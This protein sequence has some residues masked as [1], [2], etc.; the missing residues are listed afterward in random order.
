MPCVSSRLR[1]AKSLLAGL[2]LAS[3][4]VQAFSAP[5]PPGQ[6]KAVGTF[7]DIGLV[8]T[9]LVGPGP[10]PG[11]QRV[12]ASLAYYAGTADLLSIDP[13]TGKTTVLQNP[14]PGQGAIWAM[15][16]GPD[17]NIYIG[18]SPGAHLLKLDT[19]RETLV[20]LGVPARGETY[21]WAMALGADNRIYA[22]TYPNCKL[23]RYDPAN[24]ALADLGRLDPT[25][26][27]AHSLAAT[28]DGFLYAGIGSTVAKVVAY[29]ISSGTMQ[30][31][32]P[33]QAQLI[34]FG[35]AFVGLNG[36]VYATSPQFDY[37]LSG[38]QAT[39]IPP[40]LVHA[41]AVR[42]ALSDARVASLA[43]EK[44]ALILHIQHPGANDDVSLALDYGGQPNQLFRI[45]MGP[46]GLLY[47]SGA[48]PSDLARIQ[49]DGT[50]DVIGSLGSG[51]AYSM[52]PFGSNLLFATYADIS[53][54]ISYTPGQPF[55]TAPHSKNPQLVTIPGYDGCGRPLAMVA[56][57]DGLVYVGAQ[58]GYGKLT[59]PLIV[60]NPHNGTAT[61]F[62]LIANQGV[63][64]LAA[65][66]HL[67]IGGTTI[68]G[69]LGST[70]VARDAELFI[71]DPVS[72]Q[73]T[74]TAVPVA[75]AQTITDLVAAPNGL[76]YGFAGT[77][78]FEFDPS[79]GTVLRTM[80]EPLPGLIPN[81]V[82]VDKAGRIWGLSTKGVFII[83]TGEL[84]VT[85]ISTA[86]G[87]ITGGFALSG[88]T[89]YFVSGP[90]IQSYGL[91]GTLS[92]S[93]TVS[94]SSTGPSL[95]TPVTLTAV[96]AAPANVIPTGQITFSSNGTA[97]GTSTLDQGHAS[98]TIRTLPLGLNHVSASYAGDWYFAPASSA[99]IDVSNRAS[100]QLTVNSSTNV[101]MQGTALTFTVTILS[102]INQPAPSGTVQFFDEST[103]LGA[104]APLSGGQATFST[105]S[106]PAGLHTINATYSGDN[107]YLPANASMT[108]TISMPVAVTPV[109]GNL[110]QDYDGNPKAVSVQGPAY[111]AVYTGIAPTVYAASTQPPPNPGSYQVVVTTKDPNFVG[112]ATGTLTIRPIS[113]GLDLALES[114]SP[115]PSP[116]GTLLYF[117]LTTVATPRCPTG[118]VAFYVDYAGGGSTPAKTVT[119]AAN[120]CRQPVVF[121]TATMTPTGPGAPHLISAVYSGDAYF[122]AMT[123]NVVPAG[124]V[125]D[126]TAVTLATSGTAV[127]VG[128][129]V[130][131][132]AMVSTSNLVGIGAQRLSGSVNINEVTLDGHGNVTGTVAM[133]ATAVLSASAPYSA[134][135]NVP[136]L[137]AGVHHVQAVFVNAGGLFMGSSSAVALQTVNLI[138]PTIA[139]EP[140]A[141]SIG[142]GTPLGSAQLNATAA[143]AHKG[144]D[145]S[146]QGT[147]TY[148]S[149]LGTVLP[150]GTK[151]VTVTFTPKNSNTYAIQ[152]ATVT[153]NVAPATLTV[154]ADNRA[155]AYHV[156]NPALTFR[157]SGFAKGETP[158]VLA[159]APAC[160]TTAT[161]TS[162]AGTYGITCSGGAAANYAFRYVS[163]TL[164]INRADQQALLL[165]AFPTA[166]QPYQAT[167]TISVRG[168]SGTGAMTFSG[169]SVCSVVANQPATG[170]SVKM[171]NGTGTCSITVRKAADTNYLGAS[172]TQSVT[173]RKIAPTLTFTGAPASAA[174]NSRFVLSASSN[175]SPNPTITSSGACSLSGKTVT[176]S[177]G[178][179]TCSLRATWP[180][181]ANYLS[182]SAT[183]STS[184]RGPASLVDPVPGSRLTG[185]SVKF[186]WSAGGGATVYRLYLGSTL[187]AHDIYTGPQVAGTYVAVTGIPTYGVN[188]Y[189]RLY[190]LVSGVWITKDFTYTEAGSPVPPSLTSPSPGIKLSGSSVPFTWN[191]GHGA[192]VFLLRLGTTR[193]A[194]DIYNGPQITGASAAISGIPAYGVPV[195]ARLYYWVNG[196]SSYL[197]YTYTEAGSPILPSL[198]NPSPGSRLSGP[199]ATFTWD[200][201]HGANR[202]LLRVGTTRGGQDIYNGP[203]TTGTTAAVSGIP[204]KGFR[205]YARLYYW[206]T[207]VSS[208]VDYTYTAA[209]SSA[210]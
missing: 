91:A 86:P 155:R 147:F 38:W 64:S 109:L 198:T 158:A 133:L 50:I 153:I 60:W 168:G 119:L 177:A 33:P 6:F 174:L 121:S 63:V 116:Y 2:T 106:L 20:D 156:D 96:M 19:A 40:T 104:P 51:E 17:G 21:I 22:G 210:R 103:P 72:S 85:T 207:G 169:D 134:K 18:T 1:L 79:L 73:M 90:A 146:S 7:R 118:T 208:Y 11:S 12:Y 164:T 75:G 127:Y 93:I 3:S 143:D 98:L 201:G 122:N 84:Q 123:S 83:D 36:V 23:V 44:G 171:T 110:V 144:R 132:T 199:S 43:V 58:A 61:Q 8:L 202:F 178:P 95:Q 185:P 192:N 129:T 62:P 137:Q 176:A 31:I 187:G 135:F 107:I 193:G 5:P 57:E 157:Y 189:A 195:H 179:G 59:G 102:G 124:V 128:D 200:P 26:Q 70:P 34:G 49:F 160:T 10:A 113:A 152:T 81:S 29:Q 154:T 37:T 30:Q 28:S 167:F 196:I 173:A 141:A 55:S 67:I 56:G 205:V 170:A 197:D 138:A 139:W 159:T 140:A 125:P 24:G 114:G 126:G 13:E 115:S 100:P 108:Q 47:G 190:A 206:V 99:S 161:P 203:Q 148:N 165:T 45:A 162:P 15:A 78:L 184:V 175:A 101:A 150:A 89:L 52:L 180:A 204:A 71:W 92:S 66:N 136:I 166:P 117:D 142:Y 87:P 32:L 9:S 82:D 25:Q 54:L 41:P 53:P 27:Y 183:Q 111:S 14:I 97:L 181:D 112:T 65:S 120:N 131:F 46:D 39:Q 191:P 186:S 16:L 94:S 209:A 172:V 88:E 42:T 77:T 48:M 188:V 194:Q 69:G 151:N 68:I 80:H 105:P 149:P 130:K 35:N 182:A 145:L 4:A 163:G 76:V 74:A